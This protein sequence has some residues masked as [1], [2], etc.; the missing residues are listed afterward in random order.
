MYNHTI[1]YKKACLNCLK[2]E[3]A[4]YVSFLQTENKEIIVQSN[5]K[6]SKEFYLIRKIKKELY[7][8]GEKC[9]FCFHQGCFDIWDLSIDGTSTYISPSEES[10]YAQL[11]FE[12][13]SSGR[14]E[15]QFRPY[16]S[17]NLVTYLSF[18]TLAESVVKSF[19]NSVFIERDRGFVDFIG[20]S[21]L[22]TLD[23]EVN[24]FRH[25]GFA[26]KHILDS[27]AQLEENFKKEN[28]VSW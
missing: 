10:T 27:I 24:R 6:E 23:V 16:T 14:T 2:A 1:T 3:N 11:Y 26:K 4:E 13:L 20:Y 9:D 22:E 21:N 15:I 28:G 19:P 8:K 5:S 7:D 25:V 12:K 18:F 17:G